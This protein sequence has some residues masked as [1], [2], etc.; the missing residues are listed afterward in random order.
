MGSRRRR[1]VGRTCVLAAVIGLLTLAAI[2]FV[3]ASVN[4]IQDQKLFVAG[5]RYTPPT[6]ATTPCTAKDL[7]LDKLW[8]GALHGYATESVELTNRSARA[9]YLGAPILNVSVASGGREAVSLGQHTKDRVDVEPRHDLLLVFGSPGTCL[10]LG[11][12]RH[13]SKV[14]ITL[15]GGSLFASGIE[16]DVQ[17]GLPKLLEFSSPTVA[18]SP[19]T[20]G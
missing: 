17:C 19:P 6:A 5:P 1:M 7:A 13:A 12:P 14:Q 16:L 15:N 20:D 10:S 8:P 3:S 2:G 4:S 9:C 11:A 18:M